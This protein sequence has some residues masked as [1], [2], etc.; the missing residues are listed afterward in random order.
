MHFFEISPLKMNLLDVDDSKLEKI[1]VLV[2]S[3]QKSNQNFYRKS[4]FFWALMGAVPGELFHE[5]L[6]NGFL[7]RKKFSSSV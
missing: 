7:R 3:A 6:G 2:A 1:I 4:A 5:S